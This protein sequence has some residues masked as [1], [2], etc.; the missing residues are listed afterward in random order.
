MSRVTEAI[1]QRRFS[2]FPLDRTKEKRAEFEREAIPQLSHIYTSA[3][4]LTK[5]RADAEDLV[6]ETYLRAFRFFD[7]YQAGTNMRAWL[8]SILQNLFINRYH[9]KRREAA[10]VNW[11]KI[12]TAYDSLI[13]QNGGESGGNP[14]QHFVSRM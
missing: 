12:D 8:L 7:R 4:Y 9:Q 11:E 10:T 13:A 3:F 5:D 2:F 1:S 6:Q 14:E